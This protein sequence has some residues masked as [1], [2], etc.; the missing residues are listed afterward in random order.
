MNGAE[1]VRRPEV[2]RSGRQDRHPASA[3][4]PKRLLDRGLR[5][6]GRRCGGAPPG[7]VSRSP[8]LLGRSSR[9]SPRTH[10]PPLDLRLADRHDA[11]ATGT[12]GARATVPGRCP[13]LF[14][15]PRLHW[16]SGDWRNHRGPAS[17]HSRSQGLPPRGVARLR[18]RPTPLPTGAR[19]LHA[20]TAL[21]RRAH[22][23][24]PAV[25]TA[26]GVKSSHNR[27]RNGIVCSNAGPRGSRTTPP[28]G[29]NC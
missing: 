9:T 29:S 5:L 3:Q 8:S 20:L 23:A 11:R 1:G 28:R 15:C 6:V 18:N 16:S 10:H 26:V 24:P 4:A 13:A 19:S 14:S 27:S 2:G 21:S 22:G 12:C 17:A 7:P 25:I